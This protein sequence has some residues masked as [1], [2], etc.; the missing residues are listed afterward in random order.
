MNGIAV[1]NVDRAD[2]VIEARCRDDRSLHEMWFPVWSRAVSAKK[3][4]LDLGH[5][6]HAQAPREVA[7]LR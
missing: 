2:V 5:L 4:A 3:T 1:R 7:G 6:R